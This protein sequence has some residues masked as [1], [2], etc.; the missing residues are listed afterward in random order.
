MFPSGTLTD[1]AFSLTR[2]NSVSTWFGPMRCR[3]RAAASH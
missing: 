1:T 3:K 2:Q